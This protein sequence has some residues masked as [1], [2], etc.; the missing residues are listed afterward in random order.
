MNKTE[1]QDGA[2]PVIVTVVIADGLVYEGV[3]S[4][5]TTSGEIAIQAAASMNLEAPM[6]LEAANGEREFP[7]DQT[8]RGA[9]FDK[10]AKLRGKA[11]TVNVIVIT[12]GEN[13][14]GHLP[15]DTTLA[16]LT[17]LVV[18]HCGLIIGPGESWSLKKPGEVTGLDP[19]LT[20]A[21]AGFKHSA[22]LEYSKDQYQG[23]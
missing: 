19:N 17:K 7:T 18:E 5:D 11:A 1:K 6:V 21:S 9:G 15:P 2:E 13:F 20:L 16:E 12:G 4:P 8:L 10:M 14:H 23:G 3:F 22:K